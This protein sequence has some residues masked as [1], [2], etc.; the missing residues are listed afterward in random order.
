MGSPNQTEHRSAARESLYPQASSI[1]TGLPCVYPSRGDIRRN[2]P[3]GHF[4]FRSR[5]DRSSTVRAGTVGARVQVARRALYHAQA[6][7]AA[8]Q[9]AT[10][11][12]G[13]K[14]IKDN[15]AGNVIIMALC[16][17]ISCIFLTRLLRPPY[18]SSNYF[19]FSLNQV[20]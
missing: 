3:S 7:K 2:H 11:L 10:T 8:I 16:L 17:T 14:I 18:T 1:S 13:N 6:L 12:T 20:Y 15:V 9:P 4:L 5:E 19:Q